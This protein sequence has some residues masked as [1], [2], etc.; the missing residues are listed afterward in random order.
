MRSGSSSASTKWSRRRSSA[1]T[2]PRLLSYAVIGPLV[3][4]LTSNFFLRLVAGAGAI[5]IAAFL[6]AVHIW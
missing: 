4:A 3:V 1:A 5:A 2:Q 6:W